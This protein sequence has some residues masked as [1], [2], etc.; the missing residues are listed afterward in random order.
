[1]LT[2]SANKL[3]LQVKEDTSNKGFYVDNLTEIYV[4]S[5]AEVLN[6]LKIGNANKKISSTSTL[7]SLYL[8]NRY[9]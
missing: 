6:Y 9:E 3:N 8:T 1:M 2:I 4:S 7:D 5:D